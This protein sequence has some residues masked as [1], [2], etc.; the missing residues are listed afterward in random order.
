MF[1]CLLRCFTCFSNTEQDIIYYLILCCCTT[2]PAKII[3]QVKSVSVTTGDPAT[4]ECRFSGS[5]VLS[6]K[7]LKDG[8]ELTSG[9]R[10]KVQCTETIS[11]LIILATAKNDSGDYIFEVSNDVGQS[12]CE[13][14]VTVIGQFMKVFSFLNLWKHTFIVLKQDPCSLYY[15]LLVHCRSDN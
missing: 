15:L 4:L 11:T 3:E 14:T 13:A 12:S 6:T 9:Q 10:Y 7:W 8:R 1:V 2:E 5:K